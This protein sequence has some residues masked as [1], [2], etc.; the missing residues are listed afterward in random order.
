MAESTNINDQIVKVVG[1]IARE[2]RNIVAT[3]MTK[4][5]TDEFNTALATKADAA[6]TTAALDAKAETSVVNSALALK[7]DKTEI[8]QIVDSLGEG[9]LAT[10]TYV[11]NAVAS[12]QVGAGSIT[13]DKLADVID[14][15]TIE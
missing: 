6:T 9:D 11:D 7:A 3:V 14:L 12:A 10:K 4:V 8:K 1:R 5:D 2:M 13:T 15:G